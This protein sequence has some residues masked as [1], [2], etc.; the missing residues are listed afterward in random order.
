MI[1]SSDLSLYLGSLSL[2]AWRYFPSVGSTND[3]ALAWARQDAPDWALVVADAQTAGRGRNG[4][5]W[6]TTPGS[7]LAMSL[8]LRPSLEEMRC[9]T[10]FTALGALGLMRAL[11]GLGLTAEL[12]W[13]NDILLAGKK[14]AGVLV[15]ADW[16]ADRV[17]YVVI[18]IGVNV[19]QESVPPSESLR[20][21]ATAVET[22]LGDQVDRWALLAETLKA[23]QA[24]RTILAEEAFMRAWN[25][26]LAF[27]HAWVRFRMRDEAWHTV[28]VL[29]VRPDGRL[30]LEH[31]GG[32]QTSVATGEILMLDLQEQ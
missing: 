17:E 2:G 9:F 27:N 1:Q 16:Q 28:K 5:R 24:Y 23:M 30:A 18:G 4:R 22:V 26:G 29:E 14:V 31:E 19:T 6:I 21:P 3:Q 25:E 13:P 10:R 15:E 8:V 12:K 7:A 11:S 20:Y 32:Q